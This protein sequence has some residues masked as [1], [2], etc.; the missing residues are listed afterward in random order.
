MKQALDDVVR[1]FHEPDVF[2]DVPLGVL[3]FGIVRGFE[4]PLELASAQTEADMVVEA[5]T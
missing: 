2:V 5:V 1:S 3:G 4:R